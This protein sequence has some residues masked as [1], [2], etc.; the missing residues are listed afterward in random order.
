MRI[1]HTVRG[2]ESFMKTILIL[3]NA[4]LSRLLT[5]TDADENWQLK[6][7]GVEQ[8]ERSEKFLK[9]TTQQY[10]SNNVN[11]EWLAKSIYGCCTS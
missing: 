4:P 6:M 8:L 5:D 9:S 11:L 1:P 2:S 10:Q 3:S 7:I